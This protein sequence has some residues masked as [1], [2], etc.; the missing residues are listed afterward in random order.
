DRPGAGFFHQGNTATAY[1]HRLIE[2]SGDVSSSGGRYEERSLPYTQLRQDKGN[3]PFGYLGDT[4]ECW[5]S[6][7][8]NGRRN[9]LPSRLYSPH[10]NCR[11]RVSDEEGLGNNEDEG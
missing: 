9:E 10:E 5:T 11:D 6:F 8:C 4:T 2:S 1:G 3:Q 7:Q